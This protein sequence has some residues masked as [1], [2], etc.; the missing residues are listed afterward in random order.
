MIDISTNKINA[1]KVLFIRHTERY[2]IEEGDIGNDINITPNGKIMAINF[3]KLLRNEK[4]TKIYTS[5]VKR[6]VHT[7]EKIAEGYEQDVKIIPSSMLGEPSAYIKD[8][9]IAYK[10]FSDYSF[11]EG[12][13]RLI[14]G[15]KRH[16][17]Y[18]LQEGSEKLDDFFKKSSS[19]NGLTLYISH[20]IVIM[21]YIFF[22]TQRIYSEENWLDFLD[23][24]TLSFDD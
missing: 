10:H 14:E 9:K 20:D 5:P 4:I 19:K 24:I 21:Y 13:L 22:K 6:C 2:A 23:G 1:K 12:Y 7:A 3:G 11:F 17:F 16:G 15:K 18:T 8:Y